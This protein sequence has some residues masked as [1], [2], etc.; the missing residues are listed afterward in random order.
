MKPTETNENGRTRPTKE[1]Q[2]KIY[3]ECTKAQRKTK[4]RVFVLGFELSSWTPCKTIRLVYHD[5]RLSIRRRRIVLYTS[6]YSMALFA[7]GSSFASR[8]FVPVSLV[9]RNP[10]SILLRPVYRVND[11]IRFE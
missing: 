8:L 2:L 9:S 1:F 11:G 3:T 10:N 5:A 7:R 6:N 4:G